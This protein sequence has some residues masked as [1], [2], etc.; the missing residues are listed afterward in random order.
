M[1]AA[2]EEGLAERKNRGKEGGLRENLWEKV[3]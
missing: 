1:T 2:G 3:G